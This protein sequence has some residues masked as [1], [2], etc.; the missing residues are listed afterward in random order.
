[1]CD[2]SEPDN[3]IHNGSDKGGR[4]AM[5]LAYDP[6]SSKSSQLPKPNQQRLSGF[7]S[8][9]PLEALR[10][11]T[12]ISFMFHHL[13]VNSVNIYNKITNILYKHMFTKKGDIFS[14][15]SKNK[16]H[17][18]FNKTKVEKYIQRKFKRRQKKILINE[19]FLKQNVW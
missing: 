5:E 2:Q 8:G 1:M 6:W 13:W 15:I 7:P 4:L 11:N 14:D 9:R 10:V 17:V 16:Q 3:R 18:I 12:A 19:Q